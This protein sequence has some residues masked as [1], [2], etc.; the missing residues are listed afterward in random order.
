M[1]TTTQYRTITTVEG[2]RIHLVELP[3]ENPKPHSIHEAAFLYADGKEEYYI[4]G[5]KR[6]YSEW[7]KAITFYR[8]V[9]K[10]SIEGEIE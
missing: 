1:A 3:G 4:Y 10:S 2:H 6:S 7:Q 5:L 8:K 9:D